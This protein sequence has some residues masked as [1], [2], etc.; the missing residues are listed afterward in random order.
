MTREDIISFLISTNETLEAAIVISTASVLLYNLTR[1]IRDRVNRSSSILL[2]T[3]MIGYLADSFISLNTDV[4]VLEGWFRVQWLGLAFLPAAMFHLS[5]ALLANT[6]LV[7]RG[8][9]RRVTRILYAVAAGFTL[10]AWFT[11]WLVVEVVDEPIFHM[12]GGPLF[13]LYALYF[14]LA[15]AGSMFNVV[16]AWKRCLTTYTRRRMSYLMAAFWTPAFGMF[17]YSLLL[18]SL[19]GNDLGS[20]PEGWLWL[21]FNVANLLVLGMIAFMAYP[22]AYYGAYK[23]ER[24]VRAEFLEFML[25]GPAT[26][27]VIIFLLQ[28]FEP[29]TE[30]LG[31][32]VGDFTPFVI[33]G[34][35]LFMHWM[36]TLAQPTLE[37]WLVYTSDQAQARR[38]K[39]ISDRL[40]TRADSN[41]LLE[42]ILA[43]L[44]DQLRVPTAF[45]ASIHPGG[46]A[47][48]ERV[49][50]GL[51]NKDEM[52]TPIALSK[53]LELNQ[54]VVE[55]EGEFFHW[56]NFWIKPLHVS[57]ALLDGEEE[58]VQ[59]DGES[60]LLGILGFWSE[61]GEPELNA[62]E[63]AILNTLTR[64]AALVLR[65]NQ[66]QAQMLA[67]LE[68]LL[69]T[70]MAISRPGQTVS[71]YGQL[72]V[73]TNGTAA[74]W[75]PTDSVIHDE[76]FVELVK[77]ALRDY[78]GGPKLSESQLLKLNVVGTAAQD[79][80]GNRVR[81][82][83]R[84]LNDA[85]ESLR[86]PEE[87]QNLTTTEWLL[88]NILEMRFL[89]GRKVREVAQKLA[90]SQSDFYRKQRVAIEEVARIIAESEQ[91]FID[92][93]G[94][95]TPQ[96]EP[97]L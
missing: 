26:G 71:P 62:D 54:P 70:N 2:G 73:V 63:R 87:H 39:E 80:E 74:T 55:K 81:A 60:P 45:I 93:T 86:P 46:E 56:E 90:M 83:R 37:R 35:V 23:P 61:N 34:M 36:I 1:N 30:V 33:V 44:L 89:Q 19:L 9:R 82:L 6:G 29:F 76:E 69:A 66:I 10:A 96:E 4:S 52:E 77:E 95:E 15:F 27:V 51:P 84:I 21:V 58:D 12:T 11:D 43:A 22:L 48:L 17:P 14:V 50:G 38:L 79:D 13:W 40:M 8:K 94:E 97:S 18:S 42:A 85:I 7:S 65:D 57:S 28:Y 25:R 59:L 47:R 49:V 91:A 32:P 68:A 78:W 5:D 16:R 24:I 53:A 31:I 72:S 67:G 64:R 88:Y 75:R 3:V 20:L 41:Q 92:E